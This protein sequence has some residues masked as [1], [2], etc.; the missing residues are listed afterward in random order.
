MYPFNFLFFFCI[1]LCP[2]FFISI[3]GQ[4]SRLQDL[5]KLRQEKDADVKAVV[6]VCMNDS[7]FD[8][9]QGEGDIKQINVRLKLPDGKQSQIKVEQFQKDNR[10]ANQDVVGMVG[11]QRFTVLKRCRV[12]KSVARA[13]ARAE[14]KKVFCVLIQSK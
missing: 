2:Y 1:S 14:E 8:P 4:A 9:N 13:Q 6:T 10:H 11:G 7:S 5:L 3:K 12:R